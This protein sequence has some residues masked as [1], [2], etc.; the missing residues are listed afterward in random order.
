MGGIAYVKH[1]EL[2][3]KSELLHDTLHP[4]CK[5]RL[6]VCKLIVIAQ[7][8]HEKVGTPHFRKL[9]VPTYHVICLDYI[10]IT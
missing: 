2:L 6:L 4:G 5:I 9:G 1:Q 8:L 7:K 10:V 3:C